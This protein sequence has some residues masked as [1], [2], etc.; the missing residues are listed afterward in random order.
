MLGSEQQVTSNVAP[1][2]NGGSSPAPVREAPAAG[3]PKEPHGGR[4]AGPRP[5]TVE[6]VAEARLPTDFGEFRKRVVEARARQRRAQPERGGDERRRLG[7]LQK[8][9]PEALGA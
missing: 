1:A 4:R 8:L 5:R 6:R 3:E 9:R 7:E 2:G